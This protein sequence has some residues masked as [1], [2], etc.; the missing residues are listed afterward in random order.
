MKKKLLALSL[1]TVLFSGCYGSYGLFKKVHEINGSLGNKWVNW[2]VHWAAWII[3]V[4][5]LALIA[6]SLVLN[7]LEFW[8]GSNPIASGDTFNETDAEGN[9]VASVKNEDGTMSLTYTDTKG[10]QSQYTFERD[11]DV[12]R[13]LDKEGNIVGMYL[14]AQ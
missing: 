8:T 7:S 2:I 9:S 4:Y 12:L 13:A 3:P 14:I 5:P 6:D 1:A 10:E 11:E